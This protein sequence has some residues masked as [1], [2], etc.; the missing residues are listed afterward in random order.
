MAPMTSQI[1]RMTEPSPSTSP[2]P[3]NDAIIAASN[4]TGTPV[5]RPTWTKSVT[6]YGPFGRN[7]PQEIQK[8]FAAYHAGKLGT[9]PTPEK[10]NA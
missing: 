6:M 4:H 5:T 10:E 7:T 3:A 9:I 1:A 8:A 2:T